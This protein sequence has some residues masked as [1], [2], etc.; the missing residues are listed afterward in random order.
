M[1]ELK[2][3][4]RDKRHNYISLFRIAEELNQT[5]NCEYYLKCI[6][7]LDEILKTLS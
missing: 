3:I 5:K 4:A 6:S 1:V 7:K 2:N